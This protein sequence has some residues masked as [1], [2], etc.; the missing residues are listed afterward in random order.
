MHQ[1]SLVFYAVHLHVFLK[2]NSPALFE[3]PR[4]DWVVYAYT[5]ASLML[6]F[7]SSGCFTLFHFCF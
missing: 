6:I 5:I 2:K 7:S 3:I 1:N 4:P